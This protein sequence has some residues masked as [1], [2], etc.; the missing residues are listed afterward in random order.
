[1]RRSRLR[2]IPPEYVLASLMAASDNSKLICH[3]SGYS[4]GGHGSHILR[5]AVHW[6]DEYGRLAAMATYMIII[7]RRAGT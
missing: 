2:R 3:A 5:R 7:G 1:M 6:T 4:G